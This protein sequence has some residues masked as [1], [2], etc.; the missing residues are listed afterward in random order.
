ME[1]L[2]ENTLS[3]TIREGKNHQVRRLCAK[4]GLKVHRLVRVAEGDLRLGNL[5]RGKW[6]YLTEKEIG[7][8]ANCK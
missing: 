5:P 1:I 6:R 8:I 3:V 7:Y 2:D 4:A